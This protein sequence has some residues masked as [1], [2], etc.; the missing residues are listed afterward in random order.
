TRVV[1]AVRLQ[2]VEERPNDLVREAMIKGVALLLAELDRHDRVVAL[3]LAHRLFQRLRAHADHTGPTDPR[4]GVPRQDRLHRRDQAAVR[5][6][7]L[8][9]PVVTLAHHDRESIR[10][11][12]QSSFSHYEASS[13]L[14]SP[15]ESPYARRASPLVRSGMR[16]LG[17]YAHSPRVNPAMETRAS[18][19]AYHAARITGREHPRRQVSRDH[20]AGADDGLVSDRDAGQNERAAADPH[21]RADANRLREL[22]ARDARLR[23]ERVRGGVELHARREE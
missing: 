12:D 19:L 21:A 8:Q 13:F 20:R 23:V 3:D 9:S 18:E 10:R 11:D 15:P 7:G 5:R 14:R 4:A 22:A 17:T 2:V 1:V 6:L 16:Q